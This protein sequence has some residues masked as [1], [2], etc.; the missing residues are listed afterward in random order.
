MWIVEQLWLLTYHHMMQFWST[1]FCKNV[2]KFWWLCAHW[3]WEIWKNHLAPINMDLKDYSILC[4]S[5][6]IV[7]LWITI[8]IVS[9]SIPAFHSNSQHPIAF[10]NL[11]FTDSLFTF[12]RL[13]ANKSK[14]RFFFKNNFI[15]DLYS[16]SLQNRL[17]PQSLLLWLFKGKLKH[18]QMQ[19]LHYK[20][21]LL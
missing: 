6:Q 20:K 17:I 5:F 9:H 19:C 2:P 11:L 21:L 18:F 16:L 13:N 7:L 12:L 10:Y 4:A 3:F 8:P 14:S 1:L 15:L